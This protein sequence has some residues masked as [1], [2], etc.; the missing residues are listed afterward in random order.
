MGLSREIETHAIGV[1]EIGIDDVRPLGRSATQ[2]TT[3][4]PAGL[5]QATRAQRLAL[6]GG[7]LV[8]GWLALEL[9]ASV[10]APFVAAAVLAYALDPPTTQL[11]RIGLR[12]GAAAAVMVLA[13]VAGV[14]LFA[15]LLYPLLLLQIK[16]LATRIPQYAFTLQAWASEQLTHLQDNFGTDVVNDKLRDLV[17]GQ[18]ATLLS[19]LLS[20]ATG[21]VTSGFAIFN[22]LTLAVVTPIGA[23]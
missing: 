9:F 8:V 6:I 14:L 17:S 13:M 23:F 1:G 12:R 21:V 10:L 2:A 19:V 15:L 5:T 7:V 4:A 3:S 16:L 11:T 22:V 20:T 18:A